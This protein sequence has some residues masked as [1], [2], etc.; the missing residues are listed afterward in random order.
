MVQDHL[1]CPPRRYAI[2]VPIHCSI[3]LCTYEDTSG[4]CW[5]CGLQTEWQTA[6][7][8]PYRRSRIRWWYLSSGRINWRRRMFAS[9]AWDLCSRN[10]SNNQLHQNQGDAPRANLPQT[11]PLREWRPVDSCDKFKYLGVPTSNAETVFRSRLSKAWAAATN[12]RSI[13]NA[14]ANDS[15]KIGL[16]RSA[17]KSIRRIQDT[18]S[19]L[20]HS[21]QLWNEFQVGT[22]SW[23]IRHHQYNL[24][25]PGVMC[26]HLVPH[27][28][29]L[30]AKVT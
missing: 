15:I 22:T 5:F 18:L 6:S 2:T 25:L 8:Y 24:H 1:W 19:A 11:R 28:P 20:L 29:R 14:K 4:L 13:F 12:L 26:F 17:V 30:L 23:R 10:R 21:T 27:M 16:C 3:G 9:S 7:R